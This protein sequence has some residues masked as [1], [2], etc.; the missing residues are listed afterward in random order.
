MKAVED[1]EPE[2]TTEGKAAKTAAAKKAGGAQGHGEADGGQ[3]RFEQGD[4]QG[5]GQG[6]A[7]QTD[8]EAT[9]ELNGI[10]TPDPPTTWPSPARRRWVSSPRMRP[11]WRQS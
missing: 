1:T 2:P 11:S 6:P 4:S 7:K 9:A 3:D 5:G 10:A 8:P